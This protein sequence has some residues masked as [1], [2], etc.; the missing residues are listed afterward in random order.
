MNL[1]IKICGMV[2]RR[3]IM[4]VAALKP[5]LIG[6][7]FYPLSS[8]YAGD[9]DPE[10]IKELPADILKTG[11]F[12]NAKFDLITTT[13]DK[14][15]LDMIQL[16]GE[17]NPDL[18]LRLK[19]YGL[20]VIKT[21]SIRDNFNFRS[22]SEYITGT[23]Y[24]LFDTPGEVHGGT[25]VKFNWKELENYKLQHP[26]ILSGGISSSDADNIAAINNP[27]FYGIDLNSRFEIKP[28]LKDTKILKKLIS[29]LRQEK[30]KSL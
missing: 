26:F 27:W 12:V 30:T 7:I 3:N 20:K 16:H 23:D 6:F 1:K 25:G 17:E 13:A 9:M 29:E 28:G 14:Y 19:Q 21:F 15:S 24:F 8:R 10:I 11:V 18:C 22:C 5:D 2:E 4:D